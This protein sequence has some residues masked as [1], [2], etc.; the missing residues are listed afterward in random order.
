[1]PGHFNEYSLDELLDVCRK[2][3]DPDAWEQFVKVTQR[4]VYGAVRRELRKWTAFSADAADDLVQEVFLKITANRAARLEGF[5]SLHEGAILG[6]L[7]ATAVTVTIDYC[8]AKSAIKRGSGAADRSLDDARSLGQSPTMEADVLLSEVDRV[9]NTVASGETARRDRVIFW[10]YYR[11]GL[12]ANS[13]SSIPGV[14]LTT[15]GVESLL[16]RL[17]SLVRNELVRPLRG[18]GPETSL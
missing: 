15:K 6:Y 9:L 4:A 16:H 11:Q 13:I 18:T 12:S 10:L 8:K 1:V 14:R 3:G 7:C 17:T 2:H 5:E